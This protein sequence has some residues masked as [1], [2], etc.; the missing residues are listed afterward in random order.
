M[1]WK[2]EWKKLLLTAVVFVACFYLPVD[3][4]RFNNAVKE[5]LALLKWYAQ[6]HVLL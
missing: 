2:T 5:S 1:T 3:K 6:E 4:P